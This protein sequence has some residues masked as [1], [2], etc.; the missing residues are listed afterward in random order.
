V[1]PAVIPAFCGMPAIVDRPV[2]GGV[3]S[4]VDLST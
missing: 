2:D 3:D 1:L 4:L